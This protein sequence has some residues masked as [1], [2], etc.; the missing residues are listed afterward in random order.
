LTARGAMRLRLRGVERQTET[1]GV[2]IHGPWLN[3]GWQA[4]GLWLVSGVW[5]RVV[6]NGA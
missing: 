3:C 6:A 1:D 5:L 2:G 4:G